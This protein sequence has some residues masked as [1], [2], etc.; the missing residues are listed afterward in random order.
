MAFR[1]T[2]RMLPQPV[3]RRVLN[4]IKITSENHMCRR[5]LHHIQ[6]NEKQFPFGT[7]VGCVN[8]DEQK[9]VLNI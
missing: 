4:T 7:V 3:E 5:L 2:G 9:I 6:T 1:A 8:V